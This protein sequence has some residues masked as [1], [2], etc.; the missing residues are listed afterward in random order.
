MYVI[1]LIALS[2][3][4]HGSAAAAQQRLVEGPGGR[5]R[6]VVRTADE[7]P[8]R[9]AVRR[10]G[11]TMA[12]SS[13]P[14]SHAPA[15]Q[16]PDWLGRHP[17]LAG[18]LIGTG[19]GLALSRVDAIGGANHDPKVALIGA[20]A[21]AWS[22]VIASAVQKARAGKKVGAGTKIGIV[23]GAVALI[24]LPVLACYGAGGCGGVS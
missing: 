22:G 3:I 1:G 19:A 20:G 15:Q 8:L 16:N 7:E 24:V 17:V 5:N 23:S 13:A 2:V 4:A 14:A 6:I 18:T 21:G 9:S 11:V 10:L 12:Q